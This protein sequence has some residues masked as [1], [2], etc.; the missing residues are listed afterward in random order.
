MYMVGNKYQINLFIFLT[1]FILVWNFWYNAI[2]IPN[3]SFYAEAV[4]EMFESKNFLDIY[5]NYEPR[6]NKP[7]LTYW[8]IAL[9]VFIFGLNEFAI[10]LP[11]V[12]MAIG[13]IFLTYKIAHILFDKKVAIFSFFVMAFSFQFVI[14][15]RYAS[16]ETPLLFFFTLTLYFFIKGYKENKYFYIYLSYISLGLTILTKGYP[17]LLVL[18]SIIGFY[19]LLES[20]FNFKEWVRK[21]LKLK[22]YIGLPIAIII[23][24]SWILYMHFK[25]GNQFWDVYNEETIKRAFGGHFKFSDLFFYLVV[26]LWGFL[27][28]SLTFYFSFLDSYKKWFKEFSFIFSWIFVIF[29]IFTIA[30]GKIPTYFIQ[31]HPAL[32]IFVGYYLANYKPPGLKK[33]LWNFS[34]IVPTLLAI[35]LNFLLVYLFNLDYLYYL[36]SLFPILYFLRYRDIRLLPFTAILT[37]F[38]IFT[39]SLLVKVENYRPY[40]E[41]GYIVN[42]NVPDRKIPLIIE[43]RFFHNLPFYAKRKVL[44]DYSLENIE[45]FKKENGY[46]LALVNE[47][48]LK[49]LDNVKVLWSGYLYTE[50]ESRFAVFLRE[51]YKLENGE[52]S[53]F[54]KMYLVI[55]LS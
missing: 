54:V 41:I 12:L 49:K 26:I 15:S 20:N 43:G 29:V 33:Y 30:K 48:S 13:S 7:P 4:R 11:I 28:Y 36:I 37:T 32:S 2:W 17:Y 47:D 10:R 6:F 8:S 42:Y 1:I 39:V 53:K 18:S 14:N 50:S 44:R 9:S 45:K 34:L 23:G 35:A 52:K 22:V 38:L 24:F 21:I 40:K 51:I 55:S 27:P 31:S 16:P 3:E 46:L 5:Y 19:L 25:F